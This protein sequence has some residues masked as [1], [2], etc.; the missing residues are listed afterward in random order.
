MLHKSSTA[1][2]GSIN[3]EPH[4]PHI[5][6]SMCRQRRCLH[7]EWSL[8]LAVNNRAENQR[9]GRMRSKGGK[10]E[11]KGSLVRRGE[12]VLGQ[13]EKGEALRGRGNTQPNLICFRAVNL[14][15]P[16]GNLLLCNL[17][18]SLFA[19]LITEPPENQST[20][21]RRSG[22]PASHCNTIVL[23]KVNWITTE[24]K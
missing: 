6:S 2:F 10:D 11:Q 1:F 14:H 21:K 17:G 4:V 9:G 19:A 24:R 3:R 16:K 8:S 15:F 18:N 22:P 23:L 7:E 20:G 12:V 5:T 13:R